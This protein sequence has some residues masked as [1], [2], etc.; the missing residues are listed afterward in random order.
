MGP[1]VALC[2]LL[3]LEAL[4][5]FAPESFAKVPGLVGPLTGDGFA[6]PGASGADPI[7]DLASAAGPHAP[8]VRALATRLFPAAAPDGAG[9]GPR[10]TG[11]AALFNTSV[12]HPGV[13]R[14]YL[15]L[16]LHMGG[17]TRNT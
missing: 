16:V 17:E 14:T 13:L 11:R 6:G 12:A 3:A 7:E 1:D 10:T 2:D 15:S 8:A 9:P 5:L 4:R